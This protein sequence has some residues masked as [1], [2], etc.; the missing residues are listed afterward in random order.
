MVALARAS[1]C[2][3][4][5]KEHI[6]ANFRKIY[7]VVHE[8][9]KASI[10]T[11]VFLATAII[12]SACG[13]GGGGGA[14]DSGSA[15]AS[16]SKTFPINVAIANAVVSG[17]DAPFV[18]SGTASS[19]TTSASVT[20]QG[21]YS[22]VP[23]ITA[24]FDSRSALDA[25][26]VASLSL[27]VNGNTVS[28]PST[29]HQYFSTGNFYPLGQIDAEDG[30]YYLVTLFSGWPVAARV[31]DSGT[32]GT[33]TIYTDYNRTA[34]S[35]YQQWSYTIEADTA[36]TAIFAWTS[37]ET[38]PNHANP[39]TQTDRYRVTSAGGI[40]FVSSRAVASDSTL[41]LDVTLTATS[42]RTP[43]TT[44]APAPLGSVGGSI[45]GLTADGLVLA[46]GADTVRPAANATSFAFPGQ[47]GD[48]TTYTVTVQTQPSGLLCSVANQS[49]TIGATAAPAVTCDPVIAH[50]PAGSNVIF[51]NGDSNDYIHP[52]R[53]TVTQNNWSLLGGG[54]LQDVGIRF[55]TF[56]TGL[57][58]TW[59]TLEFSSRGL[60]Q[61]L[62]VRSYDQIERA[63][64]ASAGHPG[65]DITGD[66]R[67]C[68]IMAGNFQVHEIAWSGS[69]L[70]SFTASFEQ[71]CEPSLSAL[72][73][74]VHFEQ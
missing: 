20:G 21:S 39:S 71:H 3:I 68:N 15:A 14:S 12:L 74:C 28:T 27:T 52:G 54:T 19:G 22:W 60:G 40:T 18:V 34:I 59:W 64:F 42:V 16:S 61:P 49:G 57:N 25:A 24:T 37:V 50:C 5:W 47:M 62:E 70:K 48:G 31:G 32:L 67:G 30:T 73:G 53:E 7:L 43:G 2:L 33:V 45:S 36:E 46:N 58:A 56:N 41:A 72:R 10:S 65:M 6:R 35:G 9:M 4:I 44:P 51:F 26:T 38:D 23:A 1:S 11:L 29:F 63:S 69:T 17:F 13:G 8:Y 55:D 66:G